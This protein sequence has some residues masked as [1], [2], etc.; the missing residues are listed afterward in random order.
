MRKLLVFAILFTAPCLALT[1]SES[2]LFELTERGWE[3][4]V[5]MVT[6]SPAPCNDGCAEFPTEQHLWVVSA[7]TGSVRVSGAGETMESATGELVRAMALEL[8]ERR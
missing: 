5:Q 7:E 6:L 4:N 8:F 1:V 2:F 3:I